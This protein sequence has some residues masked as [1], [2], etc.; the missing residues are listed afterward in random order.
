MAATVWKGYISF[1]LVSIPVRLYSGARGKTVNFHLLHK[2]DNSRVHEVLYCDKEDKP[3]KR[4]D[5]V[6][7]Y[8]YKKGQ[9]V[10]V[11]PEE[12]KNV[13]PAT[14]T[15]MEILQFVKSEH[16]DPIFFES[17]YYVAPDSNGEKPYALLL[18]ALR[19]SGYDGLAKITLHGREHIVILRPAERGIMLHTMYYA[20]EVR[21]V[22]EFQPHRNLVKETELKLAKA[23]VESM[24]GDFKPKQYTDTYREN[25]EKLIA[26]KA[27]GKDISAV[28]QPKAEKVVDIMEALRR[29]LGEK[30]APEAKQAV[31]KDKSRTPKKRAGGKA[32]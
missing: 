11:T 13:T 30:K 7:G 31:G 17:S 21:E 3:V 32:A 19:E 14:G 8:E 9:Y 6:K 29:S 24:A 27:K 25:L 22:P 15:V 23:L 20:D 26:A 4:P 2:I 18:E 5:L 12:I 10:V 28:P 1:G 16:I